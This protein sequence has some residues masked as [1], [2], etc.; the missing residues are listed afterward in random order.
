[1]RKIFSL[2]LLIG[3]FTVSLTTNARTYR[4]TCT[5][6]VGCGEKA[7][8]TWFIVYKGKKYNYTCVN[9]RLTSNPPHNGKGNGVAIAQI[10]AVIDYK[11][12]DDGTRTIISWVATE[13]PHTVSCN[14]KH[15]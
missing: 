8:V 9:D 11:L 15:I 6:E 10:S 2:F 14:N 13:A 7:F 4:E 12:E 5:D 1:M 3:F